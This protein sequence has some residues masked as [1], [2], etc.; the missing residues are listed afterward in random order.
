MDTPRHCLVRRPTSRAVTQGAMRPIAGHFETLA[1]SF[2]KA[3]VVVLEA[4]S[5]RGASLD[6]V[7]GLPCKTL[8][9]PLRA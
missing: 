3:F 4:A 1:Q 2:T 9:M 8:P 5:A 7:S 6:F